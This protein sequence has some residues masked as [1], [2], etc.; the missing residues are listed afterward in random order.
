M[1]RIATGGP[2]LWSRNNFTVPASSSLNVLS[3]NQTNFR[4]LKAFVSVYNS[5]NTFQYSFD[6]NLTLKNS[7]AKDTISAKKGDIMDVEINS[8]TSGGN[9][10]VTIVNNELNSININLYSLTLN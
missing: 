10:I 1:A 3:L 5:T 2:S 6:Y 8:S 7:D 9:V 4:G